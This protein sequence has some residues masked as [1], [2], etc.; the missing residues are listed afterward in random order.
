RGQ[1]AEPGSSPQTCPNCR[2][3]GEMSTR[4]NTILGQ[5]VNVSVCDRCGGEGKIIPN[6]C[7][8]CRGEGRTKMNRT[9]NVGVPAGVD[10]GA[11]LRLSGEADAGLNG[12]P[13]G[14]LF[15]QVRVKADPTFRGNAPHP[16]G[17]ISDNT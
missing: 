12:G 11:T 9:V 10:D 8:V 16:G 6:P 15:V 5:M 4:V 7:T 17:G 13:A 2:G 1:R 14:N 3:T